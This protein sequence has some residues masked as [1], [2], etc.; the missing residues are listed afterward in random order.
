MAV[1]LE[2]MAN[3]KKN[4]YVSLFFGAGAENCFGMINGTDFIIKS[5]FCRNRRMKKGL[6]KAGV[7]AGYEGDFLFR[8]DSNVF[9]D[10]IFRT[11]KKI[12]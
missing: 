7:Y 11:L 5:L 10:M 2:N 8:K 9:K 6:I 12:I 3:G 4:N 1:K